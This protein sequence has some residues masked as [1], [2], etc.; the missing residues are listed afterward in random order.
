MITT[1]YDYKYSKN[2]IETLSSRRACSFRFG[3]IKTP[4]YHRRAFPKT[5]NLNLMSLIIALFQCKYTPFV[6][7]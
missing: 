5:K 7:K 4:S 1:T 3:E 2:T 6:S